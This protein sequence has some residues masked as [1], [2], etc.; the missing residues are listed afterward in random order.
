MDKDNA[1]DYSEVCMLWLTK[2]SIPAPVEKAHGKPHGKPH[3]PP[4]EAQMSKEENHQANKKGALMTKKE[5]PKKQVATSSEYRARNGVDD[6]ADEENEEEEESRSEIDDTDAKD[7]DEEDEDEDG[8]EKEE[9]T[10]G[11]NF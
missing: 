3:G 2:F 11:K 1:L 10:L 6:D 5:A 4:K 9:L 8:E 7:K